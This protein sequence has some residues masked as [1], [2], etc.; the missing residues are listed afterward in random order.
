[1]VINTDVNGYTWNITTAGGGAVAT[2]SNPYG[3]TTG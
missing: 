2:G 1:V 3:V